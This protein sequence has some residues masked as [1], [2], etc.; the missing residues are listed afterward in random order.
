MKKGLLAL[1]TILLV[2]FLL[3][4]ARAAGGLSDPRELESFLDGVMNAHLKDHNIPGATLSVVKNGKIFFKK[5]Y[6]YKD[7]DKRVP[8]DRTVTFFSSV[9]SP[10]S[11]PGPRS[12]RWSKKA[13]ST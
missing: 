4:P 12:C 6:G 8:V 13:S 2:V 1:L 10:S 11:S 5:G 9:R 7:I 3:S